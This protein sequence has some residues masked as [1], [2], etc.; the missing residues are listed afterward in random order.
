MPLQADINYLAVLVAAIVA[1][2]IGALWYSPILFGKIWMKLSGF[3]KKDLKKAKEKGMAK[4]YTIG[5]LAS[6]VTAYVLAIFINFSQVSSV[7]DGV[8][9]GALAWLGFIATTMLG[10]ILWEG[11]PVKLY[12]INVSQYLV[13]LVVMGAILAVWV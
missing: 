12:L 8:V 2:V 4:S 10:I 1:M 6:I 11:K 13:S 7:M 9:I 5:F 3:T